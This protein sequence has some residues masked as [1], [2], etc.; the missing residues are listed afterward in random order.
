MG[1]LDCRGD[2]EL[3]EAAGAEAHERVAPVGREGWV[4]RIATGL[5]LTSTVAPRGIPPKPTKQDS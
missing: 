1:L 2:Y 5:A 3:F 4:T